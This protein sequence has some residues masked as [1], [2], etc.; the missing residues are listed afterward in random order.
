MERWP[1]KVQRGNCLMN[2]MP[3]GSLRGKFL[4]GG[5]RMKRFT[6]ALAMILLL[7]LGVLATACDD[8]G[9]ELTLEQ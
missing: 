2:K 7:A 8:G 5:E 4:T 6:I 9:E 3:A 1:G